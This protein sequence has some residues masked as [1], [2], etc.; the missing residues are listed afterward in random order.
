MDPITPMG[1]S[2]HS[3]IGSTTVLPDI[4]LPD[5]K[6]VC[7]KILGLNITAEIRHKMYSITAMGKSAHS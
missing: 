4:I 7:A 3:Y 2:A 1:K 5:L 6:F